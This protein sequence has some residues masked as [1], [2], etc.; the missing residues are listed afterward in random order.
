MTGQEQTAQQ[1]T[2][3]TGTE[4]DIVSAPVIGGETNEV[5]IEEGQTVLPISAAFDGSAPEGA[6]FLNPDLYAKWQKGELK[7]QPKSEEVE[8]GDPASKPEGSETA[9]LP[10]TSF[11]EAAWLK[12]KTGGKFEKWEDVWSKVE[13]QPE[14][15]FEN[16][17]S[18]AVYEHIQKGEYDKL[19]EFFVLQKTL[20]NLDNAS[21]EDIIKMRLSIE[22][23][24]ED[25]DLLFQVDFEK[26]DEDLLSEDE[27]K[28]AM[29]KYNRKLK[30]AA[31][32]AKAFLNER[33][34]ELKLPALSEGKPQAPQQNFEK[35]VEEG[36]AKIHES[37]VKALPEVK[38]FALQFNNNKD[39]VV[40]Y[41]Y[42]FSNQEKDSVAQALKDY[43]QFFESRYATKEGAYDGQKLV[44]DVLILE[45]LPRILQSAVTDAIMKE[46]MEI[47]NKSTNYSNGREVT[48]TPTDAVREQEKKAVQSVFNG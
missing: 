38:E 3:E 25:A 46:R 37:V 30:K 16:E 48:P 39:V 13:Q 42:S 6:V 8:E 22:E 45:N 15:T 33:K 24:E 21:P 7:A 47:L 36:M 41:K 14:L 1:E 18:K 4:Q 26:P 32:D 10:T 27:Y 34:A 11:D 2:V 35:D 23:P 31:E 20:G 9:P 5:V 17:Q 44:N 28:R 19:A 29:V 40:D 12:E 43:G